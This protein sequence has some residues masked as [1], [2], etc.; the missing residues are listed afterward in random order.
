MSDC[1]TGPEWMSLDKAAV[2]MHPADIPWDPRIVF[3]LLE[4]QGF[5]EQCRFRLTVIYCRGN[6]AYVFSFARGHLNDACHINPYAI[7]CV[8]SAV[9]IQ[10]NA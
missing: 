3:I 10:Y 7:I 6:D 2:L 5:T 1:I 8:V 9:N 4:L